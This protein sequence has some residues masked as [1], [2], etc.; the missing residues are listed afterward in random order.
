[1][2]NAFRINL[3]VSGLFFSYTLDIDECKENNG[4]CKHECI[5]DKGSYHCGCKG[6]YTLGKDEECHGK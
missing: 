1:M 4:G 5:N 3:L 6:G 2:V